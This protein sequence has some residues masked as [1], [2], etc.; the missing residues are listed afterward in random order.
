MEHKQEDSDAHI[1]HQD[2]AAFTDLAG[3]ETQSFPDCDYALRPE[4]RR[5]STHEIDSS[6]QQ[7]SDTCSD[8]DDAAHGRNRVEIAHTNCRHTAHHKDERDRQNAE[9]DVLHLE[10]SRHGA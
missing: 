7:S 10:M 5:R 3:Y 4:E 2:G 9:R 6:E 8:N 1:V